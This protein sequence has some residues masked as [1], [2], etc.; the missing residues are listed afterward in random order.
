V[1]AEQPQP[2]PGA[3]GDSAGDAPPAATPAEMV[4]GSV[5]YLDSYRGPHRV[6]FLSLHSNDQITVWHP[7]GARRDALFLGAWPCR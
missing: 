4:P 3:A 5:S 6:G 2:L 1:V 7:N